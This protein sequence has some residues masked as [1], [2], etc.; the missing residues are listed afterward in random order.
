MNLYNTLKGLIME[1]ATRDELTKAINGRNLLSI[2]YA[3]DTT[4]NPGWR[5]IE[6]VALGMSKTKSGSGYLVLRAWQEDG[7][8]D[9][10]RTMPGWRLFRADRCTNVKKLMDTFDVPRPNYN[11]TGDKSMSTMYINA[12]F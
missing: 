5:T 9:R 1:V 4:L 10:P 6:P 12:K 3:G 7:A 8:T 2:Y 11:P